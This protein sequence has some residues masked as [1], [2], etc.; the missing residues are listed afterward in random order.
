MRLTPSELFTIDVEAEIRKLTTAVFEGPWVLPAELVRVAVRAGARRVEI[1][2]SRGA[3]RIWDDGTGRPKGL[4]EAVARLADAGAPARARHEALA[5]LEGSG[6]LAYAAL[7]SA[8]YQS[9]RLSAG[10][11]CLCLAAGREPIRTSAPEAGSTE[12]EVRG[13][14]VKA[15][16]A[17]RHLEAVCR[18]APVEIRLNGRPI[19]RGFLD[20]VAYDALA[21]LPGW[22]AVPRRGLG[23]QIWL[24]EDGVVSAR[25]TLPEGLP[26]AAAVELGG[27]PRAP[28]HAGLREA[29]GPHIEAILDEG[30]ALAASSFGDP[31]LGAA[32][33]AR[34]KALLLEAFAEGRGLA[35][36]RAVPCVDAWL[37]GGSERRAL[38]LAHLEAAVRQQ[39]RH[40]LAL[41]PGRDPRRYLLGEDPVWILDATERLLL[42]EALGVRFA[43]PP[44]ARARP[45][46][47]R[48]LTEALEAAGR[49]F[50]RRLRTLAAGGRGRVLQPE[51]LGPVERDFA[52]LFDPAN[53]IL[54]TTGA[55][56]PRVRGR[57]LYL[58]RHHPEVREALRLFALDER[59]AYPAAYALSDGLLRPP[60]AVR[61]AFRSALSGEAPLPR[62]E[63]DAP[64]LPAPP[65]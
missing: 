51:E 65:R 44:R 56:P 1:E 6:H 19:R 54:F 35:R 26:L 2:L 41:D 11:A 33:R 39:G 29:L 49:V 50:R 58:P 46:V 32:A 20:A 47:R 61:E 8:G 37:G 18:F 12:V 22:V 42:G 17:A 64:L 21:V 14:G 43:M 13:G 48:R 36:I 5:W 59:F 60:L 15:N 40:L 9:L 24:L 25:V 3:L 57:T 63:R 45:S 31:A 10:G 53:T 27:L 52:R 38:T 4:L 62:L 34:L 28:G 23:T 16:A 30:V 7:L 55:A